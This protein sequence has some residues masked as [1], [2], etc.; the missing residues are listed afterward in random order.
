MCISFY[1]I[2]DLQSGV[3]FKPTWVI[4]SDLMPLKA[5]A[6][7]WTLQY[8]RA[9]MCR[10]RQDSLL[11]GNLQ[12]QWYN[13]KW[14]SHAVFNHCFQPSFTDC[15]VTQRTLLFT[16]MMLNTFV[17]CRTMEFVNSKKTKI[18]QHFVSYSLATVISDRSEL[19][20]T[21]GWGLFLCDRSAMPRTTRKPKLA[22][23]FLVRM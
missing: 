10:Y 21:K 6:W 1:L 7:T 4:I 23:C 3:H 18:L 5:I 2:V 19:Q 13:V 8:N 9:V 15:H 22:F 12:I 14:H 16:R 17:K 11:E 20:I